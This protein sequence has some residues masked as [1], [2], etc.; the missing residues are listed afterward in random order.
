MNVLKLLDYIG[1]QEQEV[2]NGHVG[3]GFPFSQGAKEGRLQAY[4][5]IRSKIN[6]L[7]LEEAVEPSDLKV[8]IDP[9][10]PKLPRRTLTIANSFDSDTFHRRVQDIISTYNLTED[11]ILSIHPP[12]FAGDAYK[13]YFWLS[14][15]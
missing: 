4:S 5:N 7:Q 10:P 3:N 9:D 13:M 12:A 15:T 6:E 8:M 11:D 14:Q 1:E 2:R